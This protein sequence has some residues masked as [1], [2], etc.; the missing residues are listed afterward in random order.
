MPSC[1]LEEGVDGDLVSDSEL[2]GEMLK[3]LDDLPRSGTPKRITLA[4][5]Q[6]IVALAC[7]KP[8]DYGIEMTTWTLKM[9]SKVAVERGILESISPRYVA[10]I[11]KKVQVAT[12][13][14]RVLAVSKNR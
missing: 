3:R 9:L 10:E 8:E 5:E 12:P 6:Q 4:Q 14:K 7:K 1:W 2:L 13:Q 11:L